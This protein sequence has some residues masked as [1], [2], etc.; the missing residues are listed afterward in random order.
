MQSPRRRQSWLRAEREGHSGSK[1]QPAH[2][3]PHR[4]VRI[5]PECM[6]ERSLLKVHRTLICKAAAEAQ[7]LFRVASARAAY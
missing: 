7:S 5:G 2:A 6:R 1:Q 3:R 4:G